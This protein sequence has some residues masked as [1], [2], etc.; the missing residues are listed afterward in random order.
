MLP[1][2]VPQLIELLPAYQQWQGQLV[3]KKKVK[4]LLLLECRNN[5]EFNDFPPVWTRS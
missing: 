5:T 4:T 3:T 2:S 1:D